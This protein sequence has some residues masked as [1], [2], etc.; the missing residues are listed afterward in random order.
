MGP[1][2]EA[3]RHRPSLLWMEEE[4]VQPLGGDLD[5]PVSLVSATAQSRAG[6]ACDSP[7]TSH[8]EDL[9]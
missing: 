6:S 8:L 5:V 2:E 7:E 1:K 9:G 3:F 4:T